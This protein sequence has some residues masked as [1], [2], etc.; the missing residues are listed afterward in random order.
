MTTGKKDPWEELADVRSRLVKTWARPWCPSCEETANAGLSLFRKMIAAEAE[1]GR[2]RQEN[3]QLKTA[4]QK[5][6]P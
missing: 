2:L 3:E 5:E 6:K 4:V 1:I